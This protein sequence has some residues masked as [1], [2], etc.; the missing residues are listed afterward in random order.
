MTPQ[1]QDNPQSLPDIAK[2]VWASEWVQRLKGQVNG[3]YQRLN[4]L[5]SGSTGT[6]DIDTVLA[7]G[8]TLSA[9]RT[10][11]V[12]GH[13]LAVSH[14]NRFT[15]SGSA[16]SLSLDNSTETAAIS[17]TNL[18]IIT[19]NAIITG[20][21]STSLTSGYQLPYISID[22]GD[23]RLDGEVKLITNPINTS[24]AT[25][26]SAYNIQTSNTIPNDGDTIRINFS[27][28]AVSGTD[29]AW[30]A[31]DSLVFN[32]AGTITII[33]SSADFT[34]IASA[35]LSTA[36]VTVTTDGT[37]K[38]SLNVKGVVATN[39]TW[40]DNILKYKVN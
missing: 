25:E 16:S 34:K 36:S 12:N 15:V 3:I 32:N 39:I 13:T 31:V 24:D 35:A 38:I 17:A 2:G 14:I 11:N 22:D 23:V 18:N 27:V 30:I 10:I 9:D 33:G 7:Q 20:L 6:P 28:L 40:G 19:S 29:R 37:S 8:G 26:T 21:S 1:L 5:S 4:T